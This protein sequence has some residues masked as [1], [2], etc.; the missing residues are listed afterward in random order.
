MQEQSLSTRSYLRWWFLIQLILESAIIL[1][2]NGVRVAK[3]TNQLVGLVEASGTLLLFL[4]GGF[5][6][7]RKEEHLGDSGR[8]RRWLY[9][10]NHYLQAVLLIMFLP[11]LLQQLVR[12][13]AMI[14]IRG[15]GMLIAALVIYA[16]MF[17]PMA[18]FALGRIGSLLG[19]LVMLFFGFFDLVFSTNVLTGGGTYSHWLVTVADSGIVGALAFVIAI[20]VAMQSWGFSWPS[21]R[22]SKTAEW[23]VLGLIVLVAGWFIIFN[24]FSSG[25]SWKNIWYAYDFHMKAPTLEMILGGIEPGIA[26]EWLMRF[27]VLGLLLSACRRFRQPVAWAVIISS[28]LFGLLHVTNLLGGQPALATLDQTLSAAAAGSLFAAIYLYTKSFLWPVL[29]HAGVDSLEFV[30]SGSQSMTSPTGAFDWQ[31]SLA[32]NILFILVAIFLLT[33][34]RGQTVKDNF[35]ELTISTAKKRLKH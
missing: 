29:F 14:G 33:G 30:S 27:A 13:L 19:R 28:V 26:E 11:T 15:D 9:Q 34:K 4:L 12:L 24:A 22:L 35:P 17:V 1:T 23:W 16:V 20:G 31:I 25:D 5:L 8:F 32:V 2:W 7:S 3:G 10:I 21:F 18:V 6:L